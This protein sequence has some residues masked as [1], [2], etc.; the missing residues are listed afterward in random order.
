VTYGQQY[1]DMEA[2]SNLYKLGY[3]YYD[4]TQGRFTQQDPSG[5]EQNPYAYTGDNPSNGTDPSGLD[6][7]TSSQVE[8]HGC[9]TAGGS[10]VDGCTPNTGRYTQDICGGD[11]YFFSAPIGAGV[12]LAGG[13]V[14]GGLVFGAVNRLFNQA[15]CKNLPAN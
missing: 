15:V 13:G 14:G 1:S 11:A 3:R 7:V 9:T 6:D 5:Q 8:N 10:H 4:P 2:T 12:G